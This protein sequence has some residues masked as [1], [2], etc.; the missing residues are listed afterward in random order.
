MGNSYF[1]QIII[2]NNSTVQKKLD[3]I[4][5]DKVEDRAKTDLLKLTLAFLTISG[6]WR[7]V[8]WTSL[9][10]YI[11]YNIY[12]I[13]LILLLYTFAVSQLMDIVLNVGNPE[14]FTSVLYIMMTVCVASFKISSMSTN[15]KNISHIINTL[16]EKPFKPMVTDELKIRQNFDKMIR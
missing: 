7:P 5:H 16:T 10:K 15:R 2:S 14:E 8:S 12:T 1:R 13:T 6:C 3:V 4:R 9:Y 11:L